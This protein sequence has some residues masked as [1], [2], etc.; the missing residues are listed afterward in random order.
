[1]C[2]VARK[3]SEKVPEHQTIAFQ[4][5]DDRLNA[6]S[7]VL[8]IRV[9]FTASTT[10]SGDVDFGEERAPLTPTITPVGQ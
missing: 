7:S 1:V 3:S 2:F 8:L 5:S 6:V 10:L 9:G 4:V